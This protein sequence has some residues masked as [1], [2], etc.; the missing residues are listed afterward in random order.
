MVI[1]DANTGNIVIIKMCTKALR[2]G[3][4]VEAKYPRYPLMSTVAYCPEHDDVDNPLKGRCLETFHAESRM[5]RWSLRSMW[6]ARRH[7]RE[8]AV[9]Y[10]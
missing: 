5:T 1:R 6:Q 10:R 2:E 3:R 8:K 4:V 7:W 9:A